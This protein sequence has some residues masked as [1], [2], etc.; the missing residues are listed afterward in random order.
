MAI[1]RI[2]GQT[3]QSNLQ[4]DGE[5]LAFETDLLYLDVN[6][7]NVGINT[8]SPSEALHVVGN[9]LANNISAA[10]LTGTLLTASQTNITQVGTLISLEVTGNANAGNVNGGTINATSNVTGANIVGTLALFGNIVTSNI[11]STGSANIDITPDSTGIV[12]IIGNTGVVIPY[13]NT[14]QRP[15]PSATGTLRL[16]TALTQL[17][18]FDGV[19]WVAGSGGGNV[20]SIGDQQ[21]TGDNSTATFSLTTASTANTVLVSINGITQLPGLAYTCDVA[22]STITFAEAPLSSETVDVRFLATATPY[23]VVR[24]DSG[25]AKITVYDTPNI[26][27]QVSST[28]VATI[29]PTLV[30]DITGSHSLQLPTYTVAQATSLANV[31]A[32]QVIY[33]SDGDTGNPCLAVYSGGSWKRISLGSTI[34]T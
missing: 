6:S 28:T 14:A 27:M 8:A 4:R 7:S 1:N 21:I 15:S 5:D 34:S 3:L 29:E 17:E 31:S 25:N 12:Q 2:A 23:D 10:N 19:E 32:G 18:V 11:V 30:F 33:V 13:G 22:N 20:A 9:I 24:N 26:V 16:N